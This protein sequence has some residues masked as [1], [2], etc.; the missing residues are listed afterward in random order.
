MKWIKH[1]NYNNA[2]TKVLYLTTSRD[3]MS[4]SVLM[5]FIEVKCVL[6]AVCKWRLRCQSLDVLLLCSRASYTSIAFCYWEVQMQLCQFGRGEPA[7]LQIHICMWWWRNL[8]CDPL[9]ALF[10]SRL[11]VKHLNRVLCVKRKKAF[12]VSLC[13]NQ[14]LMDQLL[15]IT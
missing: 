12:V 2:L 15:K 11:Y 7:L 4:L 13:C 10:I 6:I 9:S 8:G 5:D 14:G 1:L 3:L